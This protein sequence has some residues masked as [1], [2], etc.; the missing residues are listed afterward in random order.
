MIEITETDKATTIR[1]EPNR[2]ASWHETRVA[3][4]AL[5]GFMLLIGTGWL[6]AG[7]WM[8][9]PFVFLD[10]MVFSYFFYRVCEATYQKQIIIIEK[11]GVHFRAGIHRLGRAK[12]FSR[13]CYL[14]SHKRQS[15]SH[16]K[17][18][19]L[20]DDNETQAVGEFL[21]EDDLKTLR[22]G[23][24]ENGCIELDSQWWVPEK[25]SSFY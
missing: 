21:N 17:A 20:T 12:T 4:L 6:V 19:S 2:S 10:I 14:I 16:L 18:F 13:P 5:S 25:K 7:V 1:L 15:R 22:N 23:L 11:D 3:I 8:I 9:M 24:I